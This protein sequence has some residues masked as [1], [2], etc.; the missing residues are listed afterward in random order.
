METSIIH[1]QRC[2]SC[3]SEDLRKYAGE[4]AIHFPRL[5]N[6]DRSTVFVFPNL[7]ICP[8]CGLAQFTVPD[9]ELRTLVN[10]GQLHNS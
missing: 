10:G 7:V 3:G 6:I 2:S 9:E 4:V 5:G 8:V 1:S